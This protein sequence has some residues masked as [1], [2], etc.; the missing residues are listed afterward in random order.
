MYLL[1]LTGLFLVQISAVTAQIFP[2][3][4]IEGRII[5]GHDI[6]ITYRPYMASLGKI[7]LDGSHHHFCAGSL[8]TEK[9][10]VTAA[11]C[12]MPP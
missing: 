5:G 6:D 8:I 11:H 7:Y 2:G 12:Y 10:I 1:K 3:W 4:N 9:N